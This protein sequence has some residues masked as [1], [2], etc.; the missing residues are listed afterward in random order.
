M[1]PMRTWTI[2]GENQITLSVYR[3]A[4]TMRCGDGP[5]VALNPEQV[6]KLS[7]RFMDMDNFF[8]PGESE[9]L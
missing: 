6:A 1:E 4:V 2:A 8:Y 3:P 9:D 7:S 5:E